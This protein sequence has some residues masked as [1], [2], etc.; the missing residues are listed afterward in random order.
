MGKSF[1]GLSSWIE[2]V[3]A[4]APKTITK[5]LVGHKIESENKREVSY[6]EGKDFADKYEMLFFEASSITGENIDNIFCESAKLIDK[7]ID[8]GYYDLENK[9]CGI[10][11][12]NPIKYHQIATKGKS[13]TII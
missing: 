2:N 10:R 8:D 11:K 7:K 1:E 13:C 3:K 9:E 12:N 6:N 4:M 5:I